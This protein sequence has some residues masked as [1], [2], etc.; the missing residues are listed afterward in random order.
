MLTAH[1]DGQAFLDLLSEAQA[2]KS[3]VALYRESLQFNQVLTTEMKKV[4]V[5]SRR[6]DPDFI[7]T[8]EELEEG[9]EAQEL[10]LPLGQCSSPSHPP[11]LLPHNC[12]AAA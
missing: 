3:T 11:S 12:F 4:A 1:A 5:R 7:L 9:E 2:V 6:L 10:D 8:E